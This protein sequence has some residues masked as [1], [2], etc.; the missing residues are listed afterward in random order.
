M[1]LYGERKAFYDTK[2]TCFEVVEVAAYRSCLTRLSLKGRVF[3]AQGVRAYRS[4]AVCLL[5][6]I[7]RLL[8]Y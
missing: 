4:R 2:T 1:A 7:T 6:S 8:R 5:R 3:I